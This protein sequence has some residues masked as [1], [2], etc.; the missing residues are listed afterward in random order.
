M[1]GKEV[2]LGEKLK[3]YNVFLIM[4]KLHGKIENTIGE[5]F[6]GKKFFAILYLK[7]IK[8]NYLITKYN[9][10]GSGVILDDGYL[11]QSKINNKITCNGVKNLYYSFKFSIR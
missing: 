4:F 6:S 5:I 3:K 11:E 1:K 9:L 10:I 2:I 7:K 8:K